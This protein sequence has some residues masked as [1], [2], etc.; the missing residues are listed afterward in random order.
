MWFIDNYSSHIDNDDAN[1]CGVWNFFKQK[2]NCEV[3]MNQC[4]T[5]RSYFV[6]MNSLFILFGLCVYIYIYIIESIRSGLIIKRTPYL[7]PVK[8]IAKQ[9]I[10][11][12]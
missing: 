6:L 3:A 7:V 2:K 8:S 1:A 5:L 10:T 11:L 4:I 9:S 12:R